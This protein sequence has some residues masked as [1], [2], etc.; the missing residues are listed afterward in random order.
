M[1]SQSIQR[2]EF[3]RVSRYPNAKGVLSCIHHR[4]RGR[5]Q[6]P[7][8]WCTRG[9]S[10]R[11][12]VAG[13]DGRWLSRLRC[14]PRAAARQEIGR[15][16]GAGTVAA[17]DFCTFRPCASVVRIR[18]IGTS[19]SR[20]IDCFSASAR[21][22]PSRA[23]TFRGRGWH[24]PLFP[25][26]RSIAHQQGRDSRETRCIGQ[27]GGASGGRRPASASA[28]RATGPIQ[29]QGHRSFCGQLT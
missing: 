29:G 26:A 19:S 28:R 10:A 5:A 17:P 1:R 7:R 11:S 27:N 14:S 16:M 8:C 23:A 25:H 20:G 13:D 22:E 9:S 24:H 18:R 2:S 6:L 4:A 15:A 12:R 3:L 21:H